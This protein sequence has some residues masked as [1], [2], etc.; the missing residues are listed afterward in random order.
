MD[1]YNFDTCEYEFFPTGFTIKEKGFFKIRFISYS[2]ITVICVLS[3]DANKYGPSKSCLHIIENNKSIEIVEL[4][5]IFREVY[6]KIVDH[7]KYY[8]KN[9]CTKIE[10]SIEKLNKHFEEFI[11]RIEFS[12]GP[13]F[14]NA[15]KRQQEHGILSE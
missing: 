10:D 13:E 2:E 12:P 1:T 14:E 8:L 5:D 7:W 11:S 9:H 15:S 4:R 6:N 3:E